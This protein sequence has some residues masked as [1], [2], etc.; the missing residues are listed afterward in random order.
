MSGAHSPSDTAV[1]VDHSGRRA[2]L[3]MVVGIVAGTLLIGCMAILIGG[4]FT[5]TSI[6]AIG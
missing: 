3:L 4:A 6:T 1:F 2:R 5:G